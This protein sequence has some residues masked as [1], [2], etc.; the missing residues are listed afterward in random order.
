MDLAI[1]THEIPKI[2]PLQIRTDM[3]LEDTVSL[4]VA[5]VNL[6]K[7]NVNL[8]KCFLLQLN[9]NLDNFSSQSVSRS[10]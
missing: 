7:S 3:P 4:Q 2:S 9:P 10:R 5:L 6:G 1:F 8:Q